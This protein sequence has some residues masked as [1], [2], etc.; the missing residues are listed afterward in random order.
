MKVFF[1]K[2]G[3]FL[4]SVSASRIKSCKIRFCLDEIVFC[5]SKF[6]ASVNYYWNYAGANLKKKLE[7]VFLASKNSFL[8]FANWL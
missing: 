6:F 3:F 4:I 8:P 7:T 1:K 2:V 5:Y